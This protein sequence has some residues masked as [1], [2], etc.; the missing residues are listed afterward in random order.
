M[1]SRV[2]LPVAAGCIVASSIDAATVRVPTDAPTLVEALAVVAEGDTVFVEPGVHAV[3]GEEPVLVPIG[4]TILSERGTSTIESFRALVIGS[5]EPTDVGSTVL[6]GLSFE[7]MVESS[8]PAVLIHNYSNTVI[9]DCSFVCN[10]AIQSNSP[11]IM[12]NCHVESIS[13]FSEESVILLSC[14]ASVLPA[15]IRLEHNTIVVS[16]GA[17]T[18]GC[19]QVAVPLF[20]LNH[21]TI[22]NR[23]IG[24]TPQMAL[25]SGGPL[26]DVRNNVASWVSFYCFTPDNTV[27]ESNCFGDWFLLCPDRS[28][29]NEITDEVPFCDLEGEDY[30]IR[31]ES[32]CNFAGTDGEVIGAHE[33]GCAVSPTLPLTWG[34]LKALHR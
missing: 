29:S 22:L 13:P 23:D 5:L 32:V 27:F 1:R 18:L 25:G 10:R 31:Q 6:E 11:F 7:G 3:E 9:Q 30:R 8:N 2:A 21:N 4:V 16:Y 17:M 33:V 14:G 26:L 34:A 24:V 15:E 28:T 20:L 12:R 19:S